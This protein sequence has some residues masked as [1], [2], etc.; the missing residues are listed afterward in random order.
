MAESGEGAWA[1][2][3]RKEGL[4]VGPREGAWEGYAF[5]KEG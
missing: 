5:R 3:L 2:Q 1:A 4:W